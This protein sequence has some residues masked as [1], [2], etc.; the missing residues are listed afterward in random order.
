MHGALKARRIDRKAEINKVKREYYRAH[1]AR[2]N[3]FLKQPQ[4]TKADKAIRKDTGRT[5]ELVDIA[6]KRW[7][8]LIEEKLGIVPNV[9][10]DGLP[11]WNRPRFDAYRFATYALQYYSGEIPDGI[12]TALSGAPVQ[13]RFP[14]LPP[15]EKIKLRSRGEKLTATWEGGNVAN[16]SAKVTKRCTSYETLLSKA[17]K[18]IDLAPTVANAPPGLGGLF[19]AAILEEFPTIRVRR[20][21][22]HER[23][24]GAVSSYTDIRIDG[25]L[26]RIVDGTLHAADETADYISTRWPIKQEGVAAR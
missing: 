9:A 4:A 14:W 15:V 6:E 24:A 1:N 17:R 2:L 8:T 11:T 12:V 21:P 5:E 13:D 26:R 25:K 20:V 22:F 16:P 18:P 10:S 19:A 23:W 7:P 3:T